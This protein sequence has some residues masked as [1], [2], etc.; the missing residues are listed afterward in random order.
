[1]RLTCPNC[2]AQYEVD[3]SVIPRN[4]RDVQC[5]AC[6]HT[7][8]QYPMDV[9]LQMKAAEV[10]DEEDDVDAPATD[11]SGRP[12]PRIDKTV[13]NVLREEAERELQER[14]RQRVSLETQGDL[15]LATPKRSRAGG[16]RYFGED[17]EAPEPPPVLPDT[18]RED[19]EAGQA[20]TSRRNQLPDIEELSS[21]LEPANFETIPIGPAPDDTSD[22]LQQSAFRQGMTLALLV[23]AGLIIIYVLAPLIVANVP[24]LD[25]PL[26]LYV[27][28]IDSARAALA[29]T[30]RSVLGG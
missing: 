30:L 8:Y 23:G 25:G 2:N 26:R 29:S 13:L 4:G 1:M 28:A 3:D 15:G 11:G 19:G 27:G 21:T 9:T 12:A 24:I 7:W 10:D 18:D 5:S 14:R 17:K 22:P 20:T 16:I 6:A